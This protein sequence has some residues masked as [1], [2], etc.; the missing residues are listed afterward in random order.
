MRHENALC[1]SSIALYLC[2]ISS[3][4]ILCN[5]NQ[6]AAAAVLSFVCAI[7]PGLAQQS[8]DALLLELQGADKATSD[9]IHQELQ[10]IWSRSGSASMDLLLRRGRDALEAQDARGA[11]EHFTALTD[12]APD[13]A[14]GWHGLAQAYAVSDL[15]GPAQEALIQTLNL[16][17]DHYGAFMGLGYLFHRFGQPEKAFKAYRAALKLNPHYEEAQQGLNELKRLGL[18]RNL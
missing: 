17:P 7:G 12:H 4:K 5:I 15:Y 11:V 3:M 8:A 9:R 18:G 13:F 6:L 2:Y 16:N 14:E 1:G 10:L